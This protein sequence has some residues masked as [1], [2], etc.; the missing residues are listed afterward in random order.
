[1]SGVLSRVKAF[2]AA[3]GS[4][5]MAL[6]GLVEAYTYF[7]GNDL[8]EF[9]DGYWWWLFYGIPLIPGLVVVRYVVTDR[10]LAEQKTDRARSKIRKWGERIARRGEWD[11][12]LLGHALQYACEAVGHDP[13]YQR[14]WTLLAD[15]YHRIGEVDKA[16]KCLARSYKLATPG[17]NFPGRFYK[18]VERNLSTGYPFN[19]RGGLTRASPPDWFKDKYQEWYCLPS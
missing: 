12:H 11:W 4:A 7:T 19:V 1:V 10:R 2:A 15:I 18:E 14:A 16:R 13:N 6:W 5:V 3:Y 8:R 9:L 17:P